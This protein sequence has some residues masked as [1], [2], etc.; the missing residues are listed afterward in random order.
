MRIKNVELKIILFDLLLTFNL[1]ALNLPKYFSADFVQ[2]I[3]SDKS[4]LIYKGK[5]YT[6]SKS[7]FWKY[8]YPNEKDIWIN[9]KI[10]VY[11]PDLLQVTITKKTETNLFDAIKKAKNIHKNTF[12]A[13]L[14]NKKIY[15]EY[16]K[17]LKK[18]Y[19]TDDVGNKVE[20]LFSN[21]STKKIAPS[22]F[23]PIFPDDIDVIY[24][25]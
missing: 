11:E 9:D 7:V 24:Q 25:N 13:T 16:N 5:V 1:F 15:F 21:Q 3:Y 19:Y 17:T 23:K 8:T 14:N 22:I 2:K 12:I 6:D 10:Y 20:I 4:T 18:A